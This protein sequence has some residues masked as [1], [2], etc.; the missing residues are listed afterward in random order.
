MYVVSCSKNTIIDKLIGLGNQFSVYT[1]KINQKFLFLHAPP[2]VSSETTQ[3]VYQFLLH[4]VIGS[5]GPVLTWRRFSCTGTR[6]GH[7]YRPASSDTRW[8]RRSMTR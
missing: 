8:L 4:S 5:P 6:A 2:T 1:F 3:I 7:R